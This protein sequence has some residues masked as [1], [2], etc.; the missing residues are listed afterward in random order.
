MELLEEIK[1]EIELGKG[2]DKLEDSLKEKQIK[3][4]DRVGKDG[5]SLTHW[6][7]YYGNARAL[8]QLLYHENEAAVIV[9]KH[10]WTPGHLCAIHGQQGCLQILLEYGIDIQ[11]KDSRGYTIGHLAAAHGN[12][13][14]LKSILDFGYDTESIDFRHWTAIHHAAFHGRYAAVQMLAKRG[15]NLMAVNEDGNIAAHL[16]ASEGHMQ[17]LSLLVYYDH[18]PLKVL[19]SHNDKGATPKDLA[20]QFQKQNCADFLASS[21]REAEI[22]E[23][24]GGEEKHIGFQAACDGNIQLLSMLI[25]DG[26]CSVNQ[27]DGRGSTLAHKASGNGRLK[28]LQWLLDHGA[29]VSL[30]NSL[31]ETPID[32]A[33]KYGKTECVALLGGGTGLETE[34]MMNQ[35][36]ETLERAQEEI[37]KLTNAL[38]I[39]RRHYQNLGGS[40]EDEAEEKLKIATETHNRT[41]TDL[42][43]QLEN[44]K[45]KREK[46]EKE[47]DQARIQ[48]YQAKEDTKHYKSLLTADQNTSGFP[49]AGAGSK[50]PKCAQKKSNKSNYREREGGAY[51]RMNKK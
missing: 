49:A 34:E 9:E 22:D 33:R 28:C 25:L 32:V 19:Q 51:F 15:S 3:P 4:S 20:I 41:V 21:E 13:Y 46:I 11:A 39:A 40:V 27:Q 17:C 14:S 10:G 45:E 6:A 24:E 31:G 1:D 23:T 36:P 48:L 18:S 8:Q 44:E 7:C 16:A 35:S 5:F 43:S 2:V 12:S 37:D 50:S 26:H 30:R 38:I 47:L 42:K 29:D